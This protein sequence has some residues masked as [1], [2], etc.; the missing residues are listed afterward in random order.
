MQSSIELI[1]WDTCIY[2]AWL[3]DEKRPNNEMDG[4]YESARKIKE[5]HQGLVCSPIVTAQLYKIKM[6]Q[7]VMATFDKFLKRRS[8]RYVNF[9]HLAGSLTSEIT[10]FYS[11][12]GERMDTID[13]QHLAISVL[14]NVDAFYTFD[15]GKRSGIDLLSLSG[16]VA[17]H[18]LTICKP[19]LPAQL[20]MD[21]HLK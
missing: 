5:G 4:V 7:Q 9:D 2:I 15:K 16:N 10:E 19:P 11:I 13:A 20:R 3:M 14:Y 12:K 8:V 21:L 6:G 17:G 1:Y 18:N